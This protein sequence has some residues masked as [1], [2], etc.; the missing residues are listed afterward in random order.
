MAA[1]F[2]RPAAEGESAEPAGSSGRAAAAGSSRT[3]RAFKLGNMQL[4][5][6]KNGD[7]YRVSEGGGGPLRTRIRGWRAITGPRFGW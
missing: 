4:K 2:L 5:K 6:L 3:S 1:T 7:V